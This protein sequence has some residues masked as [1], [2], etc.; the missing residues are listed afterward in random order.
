MGHDLIPSAMQR[1]SGVMLDRE[2]SKFSD[3]SIGRTRLGF[4]SLQ[5]APERKFIWREGKKPERERQNV[6]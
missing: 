4:V 3:D 5:T 1:R 2:D 6:L